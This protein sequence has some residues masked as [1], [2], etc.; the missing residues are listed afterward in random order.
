MSHRLT[1]SNRLI[2]SL[3]IL[4]FFTLLYPLTQN[5]VFTSPP[6]HRPTD[7]IRRPSDPYPIL[8]QD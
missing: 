5:K 3:K 7:W 6:D 1:P 8:S 4:N 2:S